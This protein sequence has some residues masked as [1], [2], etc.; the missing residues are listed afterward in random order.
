MMGRMPPSRGR[1]IAVAVFVLVLTF[2]PYAHAAET[3]AFGISDPFVD[4]IQLW[5]TVLTSIDSL[6]HQLASA[7]HL[8]HLEITSV[9]ILKV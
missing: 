5:T 6:A 8:P 3:S 9:Q 7:L 1:Y 4:A 2:S